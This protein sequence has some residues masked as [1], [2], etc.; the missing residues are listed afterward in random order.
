MSFIKINGDTKE[1]ELYFRPGFDD[2]GKAI[3]GKFLEFIRPI[4]KWR[5]EKKCWC[6]P[7]TEK[8]LKIL[9]E[10]GFDLGINS[11]TYVKLN[12]VNKLRSAWQECA[13]IEIPNFGKVLYPF[14]KQ[15]VGFL[16]QHN[17]RALIADEMGCIAGNMKIM[18]NRNNDIAYISLKELYNRKK[19]LFYKPIYTKSIT[20]DKKKFNVNRINNILYKG[21]KPVY[22]V[23]TL[24]HYIEATDDHIFFTVDGEKELKDLKEGDH[25]YIDDEE[26]STD[27]II[28]IVPF[29][30][31][32][33]Y[34]LQMDGPYH[35]F[36]ANGIVVHNCGKTI[37]TLAYFAIKPEA[38]P[39]L[40][41]VPNIVKYNW[42]KEIEDCL[43]K[44][45]IVITTRNINKIDFN[46]VDYYIINYDI[47]SKPKIFT[48]LN[49]VK[50]NTIVLD[51][52][53]YIKSFSAKRTK[54]IKKSVT[55][56]N[57]KHLIGLS[58][59]PI[60]NRPS[61]IFNFL[62][63]LRP[64]IFDSFTNFAFRYC[65]L[66]ESPYG[67]SVYIYEHGKRVA[68]QVGIGVKNY[69]E[70]NLKLHDAGMIRRKKIDVLKDLPSKLYSTRLVDIDNRDE[71]NTAEKDIAEWIRQTDLILQNEKDER[72]RN[73]LRS[74]Y[75]VKLI[76][77]SRIAAEGK[78][79][80]LL[81]TI[82][83]VLSCEDK[84]VVF[85][86]HTDPLYRLS[87]E[88]K[89][90]H[91]KNVILT[92][93]TDIIDKQNAIKEFQE[94]DARVFIGSMFASGLGITL[95]ASSTAIIY[96]Y[97]WTP[98]VYEQAVD[99]LHRISQVNTV[100]IYNLVGVKTIDDIIIKTLELKH[101]TSLKIIDGISIDNKQKTFVD[102]V[103]NGIRQ[104]YD[105]IGGKNVSSRNQ[106]KQCAVA[107][108]I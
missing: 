15:G 99:R 63:I 44:E 12:A 101:I 64:D 65:E 78:Y 60:R 70:L 16:V 56:I 76:Y 19:E 59:T 68:Y 40:F 52:V 77:L 11:Q 22:A 93:K 21:I 30:T 74:K 81:D 58:G 3:F 42:Q 37:E 32:D 83:D 31:V 61:E 87:T 38:L 84:I 106:S 7:A 47:I 5:K 107:S 6:L 108:Q 46:Q 39:V 91:I 4:G 34:D 17:G 9:K 71:Y 96:E 92:G 88:L 45:S 36:V 90:K 55:V 104:K 20:D 85:G 50:F 48:V 29:G 51:E 28:Q 54:S 27:I 89:K 67:G 86:I 80:S 10:S 26:P 72:V 41:V 94:G 49:N 8:N 100:N 75:L 2:N 102:N 66:T 23:I 103:L 53:H 98:D 18:I 43:F 95:T 33:V 35:N 14:Q 13:D 79:T 82:Y 1:F 62:N 97:P 57:P 105:G 73:A 24:N 25:L 69:E